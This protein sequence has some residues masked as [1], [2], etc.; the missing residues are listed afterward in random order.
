MGHAL[1]LFTTQIVVQYQLAGAT[2]WETAPSVDVSQNPHIHLT[3]CGF[4]AVYN[5][6]IRGV[7]SNGVDLHGPSSMDHTVAN[8]GSYL[9]TLGGQVTAIMKYRSPM[10]HWVRTLYPMA[11]SFLVIS[12]PGPSQDRAT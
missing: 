6:R 11:T 12:P 5:V 8:V 1:D 3:S 2:G 7:R 10:G 9:C 4:G